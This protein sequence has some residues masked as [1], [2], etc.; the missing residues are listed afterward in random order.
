MML[1]FLV[2][3]VPLTVITEGTPGVCNYEWRCPGTM[4]GSM[5]TCPAIINLNNMT[6]TYANVINFTVPQ[7]SE[8]LVFFE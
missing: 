4:I 8:F 7:F 5:T 1:S 6:E 2:G 3:L